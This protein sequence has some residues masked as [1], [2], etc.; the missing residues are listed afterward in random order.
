MPISTCWQPAPVQRRVGP[1]ALGS[2]VKRAIGR[3]SWS[4]PKRS[5]PSPAS[6]PSRVTQAALARRRGPSSGGS[7]RRTRCSPWS[8]ATSAIS[9]MSL[10]SPPPKR[11]SAR[12]S[13]STRWAAPLRP[14][15]AAEIE[16][17]PGVEPRVEAPADQRIGPAQADHARAVVG[18]QGAR[19]GR[20]RVVGEVLAGLG[21]Q[22]PLAE[23]E[24]PAVVAD[25]EDPA[26]ERLGGDE[27][28]AA[29]HRPG[30]GRERAGP[31][32]EERE[33]GGALG[34]G[35]GGGAAVGEELV[36]AGEVEGGEPLDRVDLEFD[37]EAEVD[38]VDR[39]ALGRP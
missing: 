26:A 4:P 6:V 23:E 33:V 19:V 15:I 28:G 34:E 3:S 11:R 38:A 20:R 30:E 32:D 37:G 25:H 10:A 36:A 17:A 18:D 9:T 12:A 13:A 22:G 27:V 2:P 8:S 14:V 5:A 7:I 21:R 31:A 29:A 24:G 1:A 35:E 39:E 16:V